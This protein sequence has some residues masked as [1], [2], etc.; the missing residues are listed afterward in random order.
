MEVADGVAVMLL[1]KVVSW[2]ASW[3]KAEMPKPINQQQIEP[4]FI[5]AINTDVTI[6]LI[7]R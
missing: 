3:Q 1:T 7:K 4:I 6:F 5:I 2:V